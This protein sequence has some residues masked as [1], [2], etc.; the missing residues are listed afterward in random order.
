MSIPSVEQFE[1]AEKYALA[2]MCTAIPQKKLGVSGYTQWNSNEQKCQITPNGCN[3]SST[4]PFSRL[5]YNSVGSFIDYK[6]AESN[7]NIRDF[8]KYF[9][10]EHLV[11]KK[12][13]AD[14]EKL[15][16]ARA[17]T[18]LKRWCEIPNTRTSSGDLKDYGGKGYNMGPGFEYKVV[19]GVETCKIGKNYCDF[20]GVGYDDTLN[21]ETCYVPE[22]QK[23]AEFL[24]GTTLV[25]GL[26][27]L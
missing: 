26:N 21:R 11:M 3:A 18:M 20:K 8:W 6:N 2:K 17:N 4:N 7:S 9:N 14:P 1:A 25:R 5:T 23:F 13:S 12:V 16:C 24:T 19:N 22:G 10:V 15:V 27:S